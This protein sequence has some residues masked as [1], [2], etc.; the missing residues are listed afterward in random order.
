MGR[1]EAKPPEPWDRKPWPE[2]GDDKAEKTYAAV[3]RALTAWELY[4]AN[5][6]AMFS[7]LVAGT[8]S[9]AA[10][11]AYCAVRTF[12]GRLDMLR[13]ASTAYFA[14]RPDS[15]QQDLIRTIVREAASYCPRRNEIAHGMVH[16]FQRKPEKSQSPK[17]DTFALYPPYVTF[18]ERDLLQVPTYCYTSVELTHYAK[19]FMRIG[20]LP[21]EITD[22]LV[23]EVRLNS[24][25][26]KGR[27]Q[28]HE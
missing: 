8:K 19:E 25:A 7:V 16:R 2:V 24:S 13:A 21:A 3:G 6:A 22:A 14:Q 18:K 1:N 20:Y 4:E 10:Y 12:E 28:S 26:E 27:A 11:R 5:V 9:L 17:E 23:G 15:Q